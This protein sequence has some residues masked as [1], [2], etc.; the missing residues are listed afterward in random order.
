MIG[1]CVS[2]ICALVLWA[3][4]PEG[5]DI[6][7]LQ[8]V[9][10]VGGIIPLIAAISTSLYVSRLIQKNQFKTIATG[11]SFYLKDRSLAS[12]FAVLFV[13]FLFSISLI[14]LP[15]SLDLFLVWVVALG[16]AFDFLRFFIRHSLR[17]LSMPILIG[18]IEKKLVKAI[19]MMNEPKAFE[20][21]LCVMEACATA[22]AK[23]KLHLAATMLGALQKL[24]EVYVQELARAEL[25]GPPS[26]AGEGGPSFFDKVNYL[27]LFVCERLEWM[28]ELAIRSHIRPVATEIMTTFG[29]LSLFFSRHSPDLASHPLAFLLKCAR[30]AQHENEQ[31]IVIRSTLALSE[32]CKAFI[33]LSQEKKESFKTLIFDCISTMEDIA[34]MMYLHNKEINPALLMQPFAEVGEFMGTKQ[35]L[36]CPDRD[37]IFNALRR[38]LAQFQTLQMVSS[39]MEEILSGAQDTSSTFQDDIPFRP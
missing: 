29:R 10:L 12:T 4:V 7:K 9:L 19:G 30:D 13:F 35:A 32:T 17:Y 6:A 34:K 21:L 18:K 25:Q 24:T 15:S 14:A 38:S 28:N 23:K 5:F 1:S 39:N 33:R 31:D 20:L 27:C 36:T 11:L 26:L 3:L 16:V 37:E 2:L 8:S 22:I